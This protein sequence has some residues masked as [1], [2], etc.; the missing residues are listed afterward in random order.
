MLFHLISIWSNIK[1]LIN[2]LYLKQ[3]PSLAFTHT[4]THTP[5]LQ[6]MSLMFLPQGGGEMA[7]GR[8]EV[9]YGSDEDNVLEG[10]SMF[11]HFSLPCLYFFS[12][13]KYSLRNIE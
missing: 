11:P 3:S 10:R 4:H 8:A 13:G 7:E 5:Q 9:G 12:I 1:P 2:N 6:Q